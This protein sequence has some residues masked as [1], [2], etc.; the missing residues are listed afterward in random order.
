[1][2]VFRSKKRRLVIQKINVSKILSLSYTSSPETH[3]NAYASGPP[4]ECRPFSI[5]LRMMVGLYLKTLLKKDCD[6]LLSTGYPL[7]LARYAE[8]GK[9]M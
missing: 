8:A 9:K 3:Y 6:A 7:A 4:L 5:P 1:M 2:G